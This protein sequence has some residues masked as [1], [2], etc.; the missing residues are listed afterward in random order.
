M[1]DETVIQQEQQEERLYAGNFKSPEEL[2]RAY[3]ELRSL[4]SR[5]NE[6]ISQLRQI[7]AQVEDLKSQ[8]QVQQQYQQQSTDAD[9]M[10]RVIA[11]QF[12]SDDPLERMQAA[13]WMA[14]QIFEAKW[15]QR[16]PQVAPPPVDPG[17]VAD[18]LSRRLDAAAPDWRDL[19]EDMIRVTQEIPALAPSNDASLEQLF[20]NAKTAYEIAKARKV[21]ASAQQSGSQ[22]AQDAA[23]AA[24]AAKEAA[25]TMQGS[26][27]RPATMSDDQAAWER[28]K[29][30]NLS[31]WR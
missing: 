5:R 6:E 11:E 31:N 13:A 1:H 29:A 12:E 15:A 4:E 26:S 18:A 16:A 19:G 20:A 7:A 9:M 10:Q 17:L 30:A 14:D 28:I 23:A 27:S 3:S 2:E 25:Q 21:L 22:A 24:L 8:F